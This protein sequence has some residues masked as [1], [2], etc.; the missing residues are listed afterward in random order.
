M[1]EKRAA[2]K[3]APL[4]E[5]ISAILLFRKNELSIR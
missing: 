2:E 4:T 5:L 3:R 1:P